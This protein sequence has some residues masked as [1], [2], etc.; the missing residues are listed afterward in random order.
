[1]SSTPDVLTL[2][3][4]PEGGDRFLIFGSPGVWELVD[5]Q[6][7]VDIAARNLWK[8]PNE[9][10]KAVAKVAQERWRSAEDVVADVTVVV[11]VVGAAQN[12]LEWKRMDHL[13]DLDSGSDDGDGHG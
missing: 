4:K 12:K 8:G 5:S 3:L 9:A 2:E 1:V 11:V 6:T 10:A 7:A 13:Y